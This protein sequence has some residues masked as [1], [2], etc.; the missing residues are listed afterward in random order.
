MASTTSPILPI[1]V[2]YDESADS[3][4]ALRQVLQTP[5]LTDAA[6]RAVVAAPCVDRAER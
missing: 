6:L 1:I 4:L 5:A 2:E 3:E